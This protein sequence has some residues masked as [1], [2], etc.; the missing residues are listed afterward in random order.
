MPDMPTGRRKFGSQ[1]E[2]ANHLNV[3]DLVLAKVKGFPAWPAK[4]CR[5]EDWDKSPDPKKLFV[6]FFGTSE[7]AFVAPADIQE[8]SL[9]SK[10][11]LIVRSRGKCA[12]DFGLAVEEILKAYEQIHGKI[13]EKN[14]EEA[15]RTFFQD[16]RLDE[17]S[18]PDE[19]GHSGDAE[20]GGRNELI[21]SAL[22]SIP[23][24]PGLIRVTHFI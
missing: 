7:I 3:G 12:K 21:S 14:D 13:P 6:Q 15:D 22:F 18:N 23:T 2:T 17:M 19:S 24:V 20:E 1:E 10:S 9:E 16:Y 4:I 8:F 5:P 11:K